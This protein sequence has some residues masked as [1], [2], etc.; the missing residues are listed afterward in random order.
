[1]TPAVIRRQVVLEELDVAADGRFA[2]V[3]RRFVD[4][5]DRYASHLWFVPFV[6]GLG[7]VRALT[8]GPV[9]D[10]RPRISPDGR[11]GRLPSDAARSEG[12]RRDPGDPGHRRAGPAAQP[13]T[14]IAPIHGVVELAW[15]PTGDRLA[16]TAEAGPDRFTIP[17]PPGRGAGRKA[18]P[19][20]APL[21]RLI[22]RADWRWDEAGHVDR[23]EHLFVVAARPERAVR[24]A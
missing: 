17:E 14:V 7:R 6:R 10:G 8:S 18:D 12:C 3:A 16:Y 13:W 15:S 11:P 4:R 20:R 1:M 19:D 22:R 23:W 5:S 21:G 9:H 2:I 24:A